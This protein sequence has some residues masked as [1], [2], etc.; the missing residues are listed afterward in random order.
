M[1]VRVSVRECV[2]WVRRLTL[3]PLLAV[4]V[5]T[6]AP[7]ALLIGLSYER[8]E[9][10]P[11]L[12]GI[13]LDL[14]KAEQVAR[15]MGIRD[16]RKLWNEEATLEG[17]VG[18]IKGLAPGVGAEDL[19]LIYFSGHGARVPDRGERDEHEDGQDEV[20][21]PFDTVD[22]GGDNLNVLVDDDIGELLAAIPSRKVLL[23]VDACHSGSMTKGIRG[24]PK[25][26]RYPGSR[27]E[28]LGATRKG[29]DVR[30]ESFTMAEAASGGANFIGIMAARDDELALATEHGSIFTNALHEA[31]R[32]FKGRGGVTVE[33]L[34]Q[35]IEKRVA[36]GLQ[37]F[38]PAQ[39]HHPVLA[40][41]SAA[42]ELRQLRLPLV[43]E[44]G[45]L[46]PPTDDPLIDAWQGVVES[47][48]SRIE[49]KMSRQELVPHPNLGDEYTRCLPLYAESLLTVE[50]VAPG[51][52]YLN[53]VALTQGDSEKFVLFPNKKQPENRVRQDQTIRI[54]SADAD[55]PQC[56]PATLDPGV[57]HQWTLVVALF[58]KAE[59]NL[60]RES[61]AQVGSYAT[62]DLDF[63][64]PRQKVPRRVILATDGSRFD[65]TGMKM[66]LVS[67]Q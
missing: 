34:F 50:V 17:I 30:R 67:E 41:P 27:Q 42:P 22:F 37:F 20:L 44:L 24:T 9:V 61:E 56:M 3:L 64:K 45:G 66:L 23:V 47:A 46:D 28:S 11:W 35:Q 2:R 33:D 43:A 38:H 49:F 14:Q 59:R 62:T 65:A 58:S 60:Y 1:R 4:A 25:I 29:I 57:R 32:T 18:A 16:I 40:V 21:A 39:H 54:P 36:V 52:G 13:K 5:L 48:A 26:Y 63:P 53:V 10:K 8:T 51:D 55:A 15:D 12:D 19:V 7:R 31:V 6:G